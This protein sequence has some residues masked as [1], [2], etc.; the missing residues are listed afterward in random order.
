MTTRRDNAQPDPRAE[1]PALRIRDAEALDPEE[2]AW[3][4]REWD[5]LYGGNPDE[6]QERKQYA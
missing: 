4:A 2:A 1:I 5:K 3:R 6:E